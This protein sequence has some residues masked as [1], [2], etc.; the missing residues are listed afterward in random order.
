MSGLIW[1]AHSRSTISSCVSTEYADPLPQKPSVT[2]SRAIKRIEIVRQFI[3]IASLI[4]RPASKP[5]QGC[6]R[7]SRRY[8][9]ALDFSVRL[10]HLARRLR[11]ADVNIGQRLHQSK[12]IQQPQH[13]SYDYDGVQD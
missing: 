3:A 8:S 9:R 11:F 4:A 6:I 5:D 13:H 7:S 10:P 2:S 1:S 12:D